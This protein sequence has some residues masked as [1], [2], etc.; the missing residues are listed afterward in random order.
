MNR[1][2]KNKNKS[3]SQSGQG[4]YNQHGF[5]RPSTS[6]NRIHERK[7]DE[8]I[9]DEDEQDVHE[10]FGGKNNRR[11]IL[12]INVSD[13]DFEGPPPDLSNWTSHNKR[14]VERNDKFLQDLHQQEQDDNAWLQLA[15]DI[16]S[17]NSQ[18]ILDT[19][20]LIHNSNSLPDTDAYNTY[21]QSGLHIVR[22]ETDKMSDQMRLW[23]KVINCAVVNTDREDSDDFMALR[24]NLREISEKV[25]DDPDMVQIAL[26]ALVTM[27]LSPKEHGMRML[28]WDCI[29]DILFNM[30]EE[31]NKSVMTRN[32]KLKSHIVRTIQNAV[33]TLNIVYLWLLPIESAVIPNDEDRVTTHMRALLT[34]KDFWETRNIYNVWY[35]SDLINQ[36]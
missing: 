27:L 3:T 5:V 7:L 10:D 34:G 13:D 31:F 20:P 21:P 28:I 23:L 35:D 12:G 15:K 9:D 18:F 2:Q 11:H 22:I 14:S 25:I 24:N 29:A 1:Y 17:G 19:P 4:H 16:E 33:D 32:G 8:N 26:P 30:G 36:T 6:S